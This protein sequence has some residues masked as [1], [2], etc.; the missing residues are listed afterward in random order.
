MYI[1]EALMKTYPVQIYAAKIDVTVISKGLVWRW[2]FPWSQVQPQK[3]ADA[4]EWF[5]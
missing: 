3:L 1:K 5:I 4:S 2:E